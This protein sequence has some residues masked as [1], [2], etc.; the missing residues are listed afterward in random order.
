MPNHLKAAEQFTHL[1][2][3]QFSILGFRFGIDPIIAL[4]PGLG[5]LFVYILSFYLVW[6]AAQYK[7]P[8]SKILLMIGNITLYFLVGL[9]P[10][11][12]DLTDFVYKPNTKNLAI[13]K[14]SIPATITPV[15]SKQAE[16][17]I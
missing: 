15:P 13:L 5:D 6:I 17:T 4:V 9:I 3:G 2:E 14:K 11:L 16:P 7:L 1:L 10:V 12:G 8:T